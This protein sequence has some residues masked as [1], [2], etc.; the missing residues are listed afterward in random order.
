MEVCG[1]SSSSILLEE[2][3]NVLGKSLSELNSPLV[4]AVDVP[5]EALNSGSVLVDSEKLTASVGVE[6]VEEEGERWA[7]SREELVSQKLLRNLLLNELLS[8]LSVG[9]SVGLREEV[10]HQLIVIDDGLS[11][12]S[13]RE[14]RSAE[15]NELAW[16][17]S[18]LMKKLVETMLAI[19]SG[20][21]EV[22]NSGFVSELLSVDGNSFPVTLHV[23]LLNVRSELAESL[24][25]G[26]DG[27]GIVVLDGVV[28]VSEETEEEGNVLS[29]GLGVSEVVVNVVGTIE[30][31][32]HVVESKME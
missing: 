32:S 19:G 21:S 14:L 30:E 6:F 9:E 17:G 27:S 26:Q 20:L 28:V 5:Q 13:H 10:G 11:S 7:V 8:V 22:D 2:G 31:F 15:S 3:S 25:V 12:K 1:L 24:A 23:K 18:S 29:E 4:E 16:N